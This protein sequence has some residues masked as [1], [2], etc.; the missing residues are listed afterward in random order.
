MHPTP[1]PKSI[2]EAPEFF[3]TTPLDFLATSTDQTPSG[4]STGFRRP[5]AGSKYARPEGVFESSVYHAFLPLASNFSTLAATGRPSFFMRDTVASTPAASQSSKGPSSQL[6]PRRMARSI[7][8][9]ESEISGTR[10]AEY[11]HNSES[12]VQRKVPAL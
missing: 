7:S 2:S 1:S 12:A 10:L 3:L 4:T 8:T 6:K 11:V 5:S 9:T